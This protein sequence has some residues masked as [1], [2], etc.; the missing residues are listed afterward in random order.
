[1]IAQATT[2]NGQ[3]PCLLGKELL[4][5]KVINF[6]DF[7]NLLN[8]IIVLLREICYLTYKYNKRQKSALCYLHLKMMIKDVLH[9]KPSCCFYF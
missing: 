6:P 7:M 4:T 3:K 8:H 5:K 1:M 9:V 2:T